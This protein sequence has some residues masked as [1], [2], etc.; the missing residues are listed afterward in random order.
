MYDFKLDKSIVEK[1]GFNPYYSVIQSELDEEIYINDDSFI[2]LAANNYL[3]L[4][5][6]KR[7]KKAAIDAINKYGLSLCGTPIAT[8]YTD[9]FKAVEESISSFVGLDDAIIF[10]SCYQAN[11]G[12]FGALATEKDIILVDHYAHSSLI[13]GIKNTKSRISPFLHND[14]KHLEKLFKSSSKYK[15][16]IV[17]TESVFSTEGSIAP[18]NEM[19][20]LCNKYNALLV[21]D[22]SHGIGVVGKSGRGVLEHSDTINFKGIYTASLGKALANS[23]GAICGEKKII[24]YLR[25]NIP[26]LIYSTAIIP[27]A[28]GGIIKTIE[29]IKN[30]FSFL[31]E[32]MWDNKR[33]IE[34]ALKGAG[35]NIVKGETPINSIIGGDKETTLKIAKLFFDEKILVTP[36]IEPSVPPNKGVIR[37]IA[38]ATF[39]ETNLINIVKKI[40]KIG[41]KYNETLCNI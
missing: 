12:L 39:S 16:I 25:Y 31:S 4:A 13:Q 10:P 9:L 23:G 11:N 15:N 26:H 18:F 28:L 36:F 20:E 19:N 35:F 21:V 7:L 1:I 8:G 14:I 5:N 22:D 40:E 37:L 41:I 29:I 3:G 38:Q 30:E 17:V 34:D 33:I 27:S 32:K 2:N 24:E 6:D